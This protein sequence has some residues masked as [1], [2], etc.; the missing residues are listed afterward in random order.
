[1]G[2][3]LSELSEESKFGTS[4]RRE[5]IR[6]FPGCGWVKRLDASP[7]LRELAVLDRRRFFGIMGL[8]L[9]A[10]VPLIGGAA[11]CDPA[12]AQLVFEAV[13]MLAQYFLRDKPSEGNAV[14]SNGS[15]SREAFQLQGTLVQGTP[16]ERHSVQDQQ[17]YDVNVPATVNDWLYFFGNLFSGESGDHFVEGQA[18]GTTR[19]SNVYEYE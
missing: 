13:S 2:I 7:G 4:A 10:T 9:A 12:E 19:N 6:W 14:F 3:A 1:V 16:D 5:I 17:H 15:Q 18:V 8:P 11:A